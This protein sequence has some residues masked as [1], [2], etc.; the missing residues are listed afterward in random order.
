M[1]RLSLLPCLVL[2]SWLLAAPAQAVAPI[3]LRD[4]NPELQPM[5]ALDGDWRLTW[6]EPERAEQQVRIP[7]TWGK[8]TPT[9]W[10]EVGFG[11]VELRSQLMLP[12]HASQLALYFDDFKSAA[13]VW[14]DGALVL[15]RGRPGDAQDEV[16]RLQS[17]IVPLPQGHTQVDIRIELSNHFH[18]E[19]GI[20]MAVRA[21]T[22]QTLQ[23]DASRQRALYLLTVGAAFMMALF[24]GLLDR[25][26]ARSL[27]GAPLAAMLVLAGMRAASSGELLDHYLQWPALW[28]YRIEYL[29]GH[30]FAPAYGFLLLRLFPRELSRRLVVLLAGVGVL[31]AALTLLL[32]AHFFTLLRDPCALWLLLSEL[33]FLGALLLAARRR[34]AGALWVLLGMVVMDATIVNDL[35]MY[36]FSVSTLN[37]IPVGVLF[38]LLSHGLVVGSRVIAALQHSNQLR[39]DL[40]R[41]NASLEARVDERTRALAVARDQALHEAQQSL[42]RQAMLSHELRTPLVAIQGH[43]QLLDQGGLD[44]RQQ[45]RIETVQSAAQ[46][47]TDVLDGLMLLSRAEKLELPPAQAFSPMRLAEECAAIFQPQAEARALRLSTAC[48]AGLPAFVLGNPKPLRQILFNLLGNALKFTESGEVVIRLDRDGDGLLIEV[49][50][51]GPGI[52]PELQASIF[53]AFVRD[54]LSDRPGI[55]LGLYISARL[56]ALIGGQLTLDSA[57]GRG[58][59]MRLALPWPEIDEPEPSADEV[60]QLQG[61]RVL[62]V[63]DVEVSRLVTAE[64]LQSWGCQVGTARSGLEAVAACLAAPYDLVLMDMRLPDIDGLAASRRILEGASEPRPLL[65][66]LTANAADLDPQQC[67]E[68]GL[69]G[70]LAKPLHREA[71]LAVLENWESPAPVAA[72]PT[73]ELSQER[74]AM[75]RGWLGAALFDRLL[76][77][78]CTSL[79]DIRAS[80][81][82][83]PDGGRGTEQLE[84]LCHRLRGSTLNFG[85]DQ[86]AQAAERTRRP[87]QI[88]ALL[89]VLDRHL[90]LLEDRLAV[91]AAMRRT[92]A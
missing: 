80:L 85:L 76:P 78:L 21:G 83:L 54:P 17:A 82:S 57:P 7:F 88:P 39:D 27:G 46:S 48:A 2:L 47:L 14:V 16:P 58:T 45:Q 26:A 18:H 12:A 66:A 61:M 40:Q 11:R 74:L 4:W 52:R 86:L 63:E 91:E 32:P 36:S 50:D 28:I 75:L 59:T 34:R 9:F 87:E 77:T 55:G 30:L 24:M 73:E 44:G 20:D 15:E 13:R 25:S 22:L 41:L 51:T 79:R 6:I 38:F 43:L 65:L 69:S 35:L 72:P 29:S 81:A 70:V 71:L 90:V 3:D 31:G 62:L 10:G 49:R 8:G 56:A 37:L 23:M 42:E 19:G 92:D 53:D 64:L 84:A 89:A 1:I 5:H 68:A 60:A 67:R 33:Y